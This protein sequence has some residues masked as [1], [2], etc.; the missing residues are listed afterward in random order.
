MS[1]A[2]VA[3]AFDNHKNLKV[4]DIGTEHR[5]TDKLENPPRRFTAC[6]PASFDHH[7]GWEPTAEAQAAPGIAGQVQLNNSA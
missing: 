4:D 1:R 5:P 7:R 3:V 6:P 2:V